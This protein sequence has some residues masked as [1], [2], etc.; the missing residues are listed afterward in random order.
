MCYGARTVIKLGLTITSQHLPGEPL[1]RRLAESIEQ[2]RLARDVGFDLIAVPQ[3]SLGD[4]HECAAELSRASART[5]A[6]T[7]ILRAHWAGMPHETAMRAIRTIG[8]K[9]RP[10]L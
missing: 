10:L 2:V 3:H 6:G 8:E 9:V 5:G 1:D 7:I 4:P